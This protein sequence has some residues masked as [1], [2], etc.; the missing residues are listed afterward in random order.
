MLFKNTVEPT[1]W[2]ILVELMQDKY[3]QHFFLVGGTALSLKFGHRKSIDLDL[4]SF[5]DFDVFELKQHLEKKY[6][7]FDFKGNNSRMLFCFIEDVK[8]DFVKHPIVNT[9]LP[10]DTEEGVRMASIPD[11]AALKL[12]A[13]TQRGSKKDFY[14]FYLLL[15]HYSLDELVEFYKMVFTKD[16]AFEL[17]R[18]MNYFDDAEN[19]ATPVSLISA[20]WKEMKSAI[21]T[22]VKL[23][24]KKMK[25]D[26]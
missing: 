24:F 7:S 5:E 22:A 8:I 21:N 17:Y 12:N 1:T 26:G 6:P 10:V 25:R 14:D 3:L 9:L 15:Q 2:R 20:E 18:S 11:I 23:F 16:N 4:F 13:L 19:T